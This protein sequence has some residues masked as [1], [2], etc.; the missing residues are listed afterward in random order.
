MIV[1]NTRRNG[2]YQLNTNSNEN[3]KKNEYKKKKRDIFLETHE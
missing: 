3:A 2:L 1:S